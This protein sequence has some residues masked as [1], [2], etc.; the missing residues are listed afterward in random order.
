M[1]RKLLMQQILAPGTRW[2]RFGQDDCRKPGWPYGWAS[3]T[4]HAIPR[5]VW[6]AW[7]DQ[8]DV[9]LA[10]DANLHLTPDANG[11]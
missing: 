6:K 8:A 2:E 7:Y 11:R 9:G 4:D 10:G 1:A 3:G 5:C